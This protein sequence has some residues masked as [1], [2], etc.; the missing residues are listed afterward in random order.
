MNVFFAHPIW[1]YLLLVNGYVFFL[2]AYDKRR[3]QKHQWRI[4]ESNMLFMGIIGGG[5]GGLAAQRL[6]RHK[7]LKRKFTICFIIGILFDAALV[8]YLL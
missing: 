2:M 3:A 5:L 8:F 6:F 1:F 4:P 7:T